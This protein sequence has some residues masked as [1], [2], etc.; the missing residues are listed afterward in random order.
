MDF[1][2]AGGQNVYFHV[3]GQGNGNVQ[4]LRMG[5]RVSYTEMSDSTGACAG[6][7][8]PIEGVCVCVCVHVSSRRNGDRK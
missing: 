8:K 5:Q 6:N 2:D 4:S 1:G 7:V 3:N